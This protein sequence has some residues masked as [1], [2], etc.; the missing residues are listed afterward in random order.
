MIINKEMAQFMANRE[1][2]PWRCRSFDSVKI[3]IDMESPP[4]VL[5]HA[6]ERVPVLPI[7]DGDFLH[8]GNCVGINTSGR[9]VLV[10]NAFGELGQFYGKSIGYPIPILLFAHPT[11]AQPRL[12]PVPSSSS[13]HPEFRHQNEPPE[14]DSL[15]YR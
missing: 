10:S 12:G 2:S 8:A 9:A 4:L 1:P 7:A 6:V 11:L 14:R 3:H 5:K 13:H 15:P